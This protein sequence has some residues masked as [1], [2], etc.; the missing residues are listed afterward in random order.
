[1]FLPSILGATLRRLT[2]GADVTNGETGD[3]AIDGDA[4]NDRLNGAGGNDILS[5]GEGN[6]QINGDAG[7]DLLAGGAGDDTL[8][9]GAGFDVVSYEDATGGVTVNLG[10]TSPQATGAAGRDRI[11]GI[12][13]LIGTGFGDRLTG[14]AFANLLAGGAGH[15][16]LFGGTGNDTLFGGAGNDVLDGGTGIDTADYSDVTGDLA[17]SLATTRGQNTGAAGVDQLRGIERLVGGFGNDR[18]TGSRASDTLVGGAGDDTLN[19][20]AGRDTLVGGDGDDTFVIDSANDVIVE[21]V[22]GGQDTVLSPISLV[23]APAL[24]NL[25]LLESRSAIMATGNSAGNV[26]IGNGRNNTLS[27]LAGDD[28]LDGGAGDDTLDGGDGTDTASYAAARTGLQIDLSLT[29]SQN[30][31]SLGRDTLIRIENL[32]GG[33]GNDT[34]LGDAGDNLLDGGTGADRIEGGDGND[35]L[36]GGDGNDRLT[37]GTGDDSIA[38]G[39]GT[40]TAVYAEALADVVVTWDAATGS[41]VIETASGDD[42]V[43]G[44]ELFDFAGTVVD[45][46]ELRA[47]RLGSGDDSYTVGPDG[48]RVLGLAGN[49]NLS[50]GAGADQ[51]E[52]GDGVDTLTGAGGN[53]TL[54]GG[55]GNDTLVAGEGNDTVDGGSGADRLVIAHT[56]GQSVAITREDDTWIIT[57]PLGRTVARNIESLVLGSDLGTDRLPLLAGLAVS[58]TSLAEGDSGTTDLEARVTLDRPAPAALTLGYA[59]TAAVDGDGIDAVDFEGGLP[60]GTVTIAAGETTADITI[61]VRGDTTPEQTEAFRIALVD[62]PVGV[63]KGVESVTVTI[64]DDE[65]RQLTAGADRFSGT[66]VGDKVDG[67]AGNDQLR[68]LDGDDVLAGGIGN[69]QLDGGN[70]NDT[71]SGGAGDDTLIGGSG[72]DTVTYAAA[73]SGVAVSLDTTALQAT[74]AEGRDRL[75]GVEALIGSAHDDTLIGSL[76]ANV[77]TGGDG[78]DILDGGRGNDTLYG[79]SGNDT[80]IGGAGINRLEGG[81]GDDRYE[82]E[83]PRDI[84]V[85]LAGG[86]T[87]H[88]FAQQSFALA[89]QVENLTLLGLRDISGTGNGLDNEIVGNTRSNTL[90]GLGGN[91]VIRGDRGNDDI[92]GGDGN[93]TLFGDA[94]LDRLRGEAGNDVLLGLLDND[95][96]EGG[97]GDDTLDGGAGRD[98]LI[99]GAG[100]DI[101]IVDDAGDVLVEDTDGGIDTVR[102]QISWTLG[103]NLE[104]LV[105]TDASAV[106]GTGN[107]LDNTLTGSA[108]NNLLQGLA[109]NDTLRGE[110][111]HDVLDGGTGNDVLDG[112]AGVDTASYA[113]ASAGVTVSLA[114]SAAQD[115]GGAGTDTLVAIE[116]LVGSGQSDRLAGDEGANVLTGGAGADVFVFADGFGLDRITDFAPGTTGEVI[117]FAAVTDIVDHADLTAN[118]LGSDA[119]GNAVITVGSN[120]LTLVGVAKN[121][122]AADDFM[123]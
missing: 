24:E 32:I 63:L 14:N 49:D 30:L 29:G 8:S 46:V 100:N 71:L 75:L 88:V 117:D 104:N 122:L 1:M 3:E 114:L 52:G 48:G 19:G 69:D 38:G 119:D 90:R 2:G 85:E 81:A 21:Q 55:A 13:G 89:D 4:G 107:A 79:G 34:L 36:L 15:D 20:G 43:T 33:T 16:S 18:L 74:G 59:V 97:D 53:D 78:A 101:L 111:G 93:D 105:L 5:G 103:D 118:H 35:I 109:G 98:R 77:L 44:V 58:A 96:L 61:R 84:I 11:L 40:D 10:V 115:T 82:V 6:D 95:T 68:G 26:L 108:G 57:G 27:G 99:G 83:D 65:A 76:I 41:Y 123:F 113:E 70:G 7:D 12:E 42:V 25:Q 72:F 102:A 51:L 28:T 45:A 56:T 67:G 22:D 66:S 54:W 23:L 80:L 9:G 60:A 86:G 50:G 39:D 37:G 110:A 17:V 94:G 92:L 73:A 112:G 62:L 91:D 64:I 121:S 31:G 106:L 120:V 87:D 116:N 47:V